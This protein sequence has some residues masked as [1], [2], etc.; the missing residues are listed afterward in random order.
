MPRPQPTSV[1]SASAAAMPHL[2]CAACPHEWGGHDP[3][4]ARFCS[5]SAAAGLDRGCV[6]VKDVALFDPRGR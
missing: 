5:A 4:G 6:C 3:I 2:I 1:V